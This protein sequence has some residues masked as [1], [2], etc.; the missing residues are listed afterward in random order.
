[1]PKSIGVRIADFHAELEQAQET[2]LQRQQVEIFPEDMPYYLWL[3]EKDWSKIVGAP[4]VLPPNTTKPAF[5]I[6]PLTEEIKPSEIKSTVSNNKN[7]NYQQVQAYILSPTLNREIFLELEEKLKTFERSDSDSNVF[8]CLALLYLKHGQTADGTHYL[9]RAIKAGHISAQLYLTYYPTK[10]SGSSDDIVFV[11]KYSDFDSDLRSIFQRKDLS[12]IPFDLRNR[13][14]WIRETDYDGFAELTT[15]LGRQLYDPKEP[16]ISAP[17]W[18]GNFYETY[19]HRKL[20]CQNGSYL[21]QAYWN[22]AIRD[23]GEK[24]PAGFFQD[25]IRE[26]GDILIKAM[27]LGDPRASFNIGCLYYL[28]RKNKLI[29]DTLV[30]VMQLQGISLPRTDLAIYFWEKS[31]LSQ[32]TENIQALG[33]IQ[34]KKL[35]VT[36]QFLSLTGDED[37]GFIHHT[38]TRPASTFTKISSATDVMPM[39]S[40][41]M[42]EVKSMAPEVV[43]VEEDKNFHLKMAFKAQLAIGLRMQ[44]IYTQGQANP[45]DKWALAFLLL[46]FS[47]SLWEAT[48]QNPDMSGFGSD[49]AIKNFR[50]IACHEALTEAKA[51]DLTITASMVAASRPNCFE[52]IKDSMELSAEE[53]SVLA[54]QKVRNLNIG[55]LPLHQAFPTRY[56]NRSEFHTEEKIFQK[57]SGL[58]SEWQALNAVTPK[59]YTALAGIFVACGE[60]SFEKT[61]TAGDRSRKGRAANQIYGFIAE[62]RKFRNECAHQSS[63]LAEDVVG[64]QYI[65]NLCTTAAMVELAWLRP[66]T[67]TSNT[68]QTGLFGTRQASNLTAT[69]PVINHHRP[70]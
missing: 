67:E 28:A 4:R 20:V 70:G 57:L 69:P 25:S 22:T 11:N 45:S 38:F 12:K 29:A 33:K 58:L 17:L 6:S 41:V 2:E 36:L 55:T 42:D 30:K 52:L 9:K 53:K 54:T 19:F 65:D 63:F 13:I 47:N 1:M 64:K 15:E 23:Q 68:A 14:F 32:A 46:I 59:N 51:D 60:G 26:L 62:C 49:L 37:I 34:G 48:Y 44:E 16:H 31:P 66:Y 21:A 61:M 3:N 43:T 10:K 27:Q 40:T 39:T 18:S 35:D 8:Y 24:M 5:C 56:L 7:K 50:L